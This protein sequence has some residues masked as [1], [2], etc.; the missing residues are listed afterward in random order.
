[1]SLPSISSFVAR[2]SSWVSL[3]SSSHVLLG[4]TSSIFWGL[5]LAALTWKALA[6]AYDPSGRILI[7]VVATCL[8]LFAFVYTCTD[9]HR[10]LENQ[11]TIHRS[12]MQVTP[13]AVIAAVYGMAQGWN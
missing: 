3:R 10:W 6:L 9:S 4:P 5:C 2:Y 7:G 11:I 1:M 13:L 8:V 12:M